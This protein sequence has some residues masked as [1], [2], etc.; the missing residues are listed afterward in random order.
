MTSPLVKTNL[1]SALHM[2][3]I[4]IK[5]CLKEGVTLSDR[6]K[7]VG[8]FGRPKSSVTPYW[9]GWPLAVPTVTVGVVA[10]KLIT[11]ASLEKYNP[12][13]PESTISV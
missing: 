8:K 5:V 4:P 13:A 1:Q 12:L 7:Y 9:W 2:G 11:G 6:G 10:S 3:P